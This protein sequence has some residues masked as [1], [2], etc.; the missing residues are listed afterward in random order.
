MKNGT[1]GDKLQMWERE[2]KEPEKLFAGEKK[3]TADTHKHENVKAQTNESGL[4][5]LFS[6]LPSAMNISQGEEPQPKPVK[7]KKK[8]PRQRLS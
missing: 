5:S 6:V 3:N 4:G 7:K 1:V 2:L 8:K